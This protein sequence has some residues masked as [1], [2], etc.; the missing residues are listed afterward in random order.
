PVPPAGACRAPPP[1]ATVRF[2]NG[3][4]AGRRGHAR[5]GVRGGGGL[6]LVPADSRAAAAAWLR[7]N[8]RGYEEH[9]DVRF[10]HKDGKSVWA[11][12][13]AAPLFDDAGGFAGTLAM[14][15]DMTA[16]RELEAQLRQAEKEGGVW[17]MWGGV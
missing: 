10:R 13:A 8:R 6:D 5:E 1:Q 16:R 11:L 7:H 17:G 3:R 12:V 9:G 2:A 15:T 4:M 14:V